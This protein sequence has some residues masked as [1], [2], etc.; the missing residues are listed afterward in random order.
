[1]AYAHGWPK[2]MG[3][4]E[5][6]SSFPDPLGIGH[7]L[8]LALTVFAELV[9]AVLL[10]LGAATRWAAIPFTITMVVATFIIHADDPFA[11][12]ELALLYAALSL[13]L[14]CTGPGNLSIDHW[15]ARRKLS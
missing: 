11:K 9:C 1:M 3:F 12:K 8:S 14:L 7:E 15:R 4:A 5:K 2:L 6:A 13:C 10:A